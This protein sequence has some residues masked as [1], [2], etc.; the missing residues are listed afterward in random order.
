LKEKGGGIPVVAV[1]AV[2]IA[3][4]VVISSGAKE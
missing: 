2:I 3:I 4:M 1:V